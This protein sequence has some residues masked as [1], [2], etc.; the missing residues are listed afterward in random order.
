MPEYSVDSDGNL[1]QHDPWDRGLEWPQD[2]DVTRIGDVRLL[3]VSGKGYGF[4]AHDPLS[5]DYA[6]E[7]I[8]DFERPI[9]RISILANLYENH[10]HGRIPALRLA[11]FLA[12]F[13]ASEKEPLLVST[14]LSYLNSMAY[15]GETSLLPELEA[16]LANLARNISLG[17]EQT[18]AFKSLTGF[19]RSPDLAEE[20]YKIW[21]EQKPWL[22]V[23]LSETDYTSLA[24]QLA[25]R[26][27]ERSES[28]LRE[29]RAR[30][31][32]ADRIRE[33]DF[34]RPAVSPDKS[35]RDS[36]F[37]ALL[38]PENRR[39]E[40]WAEDA[41]E[42]LNHPLRQAQALDYIRPALEALEDVQ[43]TGDIFFPKRWVA[44]TLHGHSSPE[45]DALVDAFLDAHPNYPP[46]LKDKILQAATRWK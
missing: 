35:V 7:H 45:A 32:G 28:I 29:Q 39:V 33:F 18:S 2:I 21:K 43:R 8:N 17:Q 22:G 16:L 36:V 46:L 11:N 44:A 23:K 4:F 5:L 1:Q 19:F 9:E 37:N 10:L 3:N 27:P 13:A 38:K 30:I 14:A 24:L 42:Y 6:M 25:V 41:L 15:Q 40:P 20:L 34:I 31:S 26:L 12:G